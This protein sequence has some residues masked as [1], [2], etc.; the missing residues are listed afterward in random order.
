[1]KP[2]PFEY[3]APQSVE[4]ALTHLTEHGYDAKVLAGGQSLIPMLN[5]RL[6]QPEVLV[7]LNCNHPNPQPRHYRRQYCAC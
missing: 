4:E 7:D 5:F 3:Y 1:M 6:A 2:P